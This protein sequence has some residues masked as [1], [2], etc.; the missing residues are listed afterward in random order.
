MTP[1]Q[2]MAAQSH[3]VSRARQRGPV[4]VKPLSDA[5]ANPLGR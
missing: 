2:A 3:Q 5:V 4:Q 1:P